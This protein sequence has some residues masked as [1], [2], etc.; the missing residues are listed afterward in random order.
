MANL[1]ARLLGLGAGNKKVEWM[2]PYVKGCSVL[3]LGCVQGKGAY[4]KANWLHAQLAS[5]ANYCIGLDLDEQEIQKI[6]SYGYNMIFGDAQDITLNEFVDVVVAADILEHLHDWKGFFVGVRGALKEHGRL[7]I[8][9]PN[10]WFFLRFIRCLLKGDAGVHP[11]HVAWFCSGTIGELLKRYGFGI[12]DLQYGS[13]EPI[14][15]RLGVIRP[16]LFHTSIFVVANK[17]T[18]AEMPAEKIN[19]QQ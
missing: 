10:P 13:G 14:F 8:T 2:I 4:L 6:K 11:E 7:I 1:F 3:D 16:I 12:E 9:I 17:I 19:G 15:Y 5:A 18:F